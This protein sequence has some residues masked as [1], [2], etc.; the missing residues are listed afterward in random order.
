MDLLALHRG[1]AA[2]H[3]VFHGGGPDAP[4][5]MAALYRASGLP[6]QR[7]KD[8]ALRDWVH[9]DPWRTLRLLGEIAPRGTRAVVTKLFPRFLDAS[10]VD[11]QLAA[12]PDT[13][14]LI[15]TRR[16]ID[17]YISLI[18]ARSVNRWANFDSTHLRPALDPIDFVSWHAAQS[19]WFALIQAAT[20]RHGRPTASLT[21][22]HDVLGVDPVTATG[23]RRALA[24]VGL[25]GELRWTWRARQQ[26][27]RLV[28]ATASRIGLSGRWLEGT[29]LAPQDRSR[30]VKD[31]VSNWEAFRAELSV[32]HDLQMLERY[33]SG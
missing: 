17:T 31:K 15:L 24:E 19:H 29:G 11:A 13:A 26:V 30:A 1:L 32:H 27:K 18:K 9:Q 33:G 23:I 14:F 5:A 25:P 21:Y 7:R 4:T 8:P 22:E 2:F 6:P 10:A 16:P 28:R 20:L 12:A 3:E